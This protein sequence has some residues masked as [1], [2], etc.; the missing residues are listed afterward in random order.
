VGSVNFRRLILAILLLVVSLLAQT[1]EEPKLASIH[2]T[3]TDAGTGQPIVKVVVKL[4]QMSPAVEQDDAP[5]ATTTP[6]GEY[7]FKSVRPGEYY[8]VATKTGYLRAT[9]GKST[10]PRSSGTPIGVTAGATLSNIDLKIQRGGVIA[11]HVLN[12]D[13]EPFTNVRVEAMTYMRFSG[14]RRLVPAGSAQTDDR[15]EYRIHDL[16]PGTYYLL[17]LPQNRYD[18]TPAASEPKQAYA[19]VYY[20]TSSSVD[21]ATPLKITSGSEEVAHFSVSPSAAYTIR[22]TVSGADTAVS[23]VA[24]PSG[25]AFSFGGPQTYTSGNTFELKNVTPGKY[26]LL[27]FSRKDEKQRT[28]SQKVTVVD[29][30]ISNVTLN[31]Q[32]TPTEIHGTLQFIGD[33]VGARSVLNVILGPPMRDRDDDDNMWMLGGGYGEVTKEGSFTLTPSPASGNGFLEVYGPH[34]EDYYVKSVHFGTRDVTETG[35]VPSTGAVLQVVLSANS[36]SIEGLVTD[37]NNKPFPGAHVRILPEESRRARPDLYQSSTSDQ[38]GYFRIQGVAPGTYTVL[39]LEDPEQ[40]PPFDPDFLKAHLSDGQS[41]TAEEKGRYN[42]KVTVIP[43]ET[44]K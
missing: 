23:I 24:Q 8:L 31:F 39:A 37:K 14:R 40:S 5:T 11:G 38:R 2:G 42:I 13:G 28:T 15:G 18:P 6:S 27:A 43:A 22:G 17:C 26:T 41:L 12:E 21:S 32:N 10:N 33:P 4:E 3:V 35:F 44:V 7:E 25:N 16:W 30:D 29:A 1:K 19:S 9:Y 36:A 34:L 20:P